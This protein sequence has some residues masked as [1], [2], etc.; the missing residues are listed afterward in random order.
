MDHTP[1]VTLRRR[2]GAAQYPSSPGLSPIGPQ[3]CIAR[4]DDS[5]GAI[6]D[7]HL[8]QILETWFRTV[9]RLMDN[10]SAMRVLASPRA[11]SSKISRSRLV[12]SENTSC[13]SSCREE[14]KKLIILLATPGL[15]IASPDATAWMARTND[16]RA[17]H[18]GVKG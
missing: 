9:F 8:L 10:R 5:L 7:L 6:N 12:R 16:K 17:P 14:A 3:T 1:Q 4:A 15:K 2:R 18:Q 11:I 13:G